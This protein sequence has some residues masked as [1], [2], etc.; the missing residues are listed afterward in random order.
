MPTTLL[1]LM[2][3][4]EVKLYINGKH[5][6]RKADILMEI[7]TAMIINMLASFLSIDYNYGQNKNERGGAA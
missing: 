1:F 7:K 6:D 3:L 2:H 4:P 5:S